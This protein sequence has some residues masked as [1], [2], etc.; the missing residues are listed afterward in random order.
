MK[1]RQIVSK[2]R[3][4]FRA[5]IRSINA[6]MLYH[7]ILYFKSQPIAVSQKS[8][9]VFSPHQ[10]DETLGCGG[11]IALKRS[12]GV[13][14]E[15]VFLTDGRYGRPDW[16]KAEMIAEIR[17]REALNALDIL[18][19]ANS[20][21]H[22]LNQIDGSLQYL[23]NDQ[24]QHIID[25]LAQRLRLFMPE[26]VYVPHRKDVHGDHE[27][28]YQ[29]VKEAIAA[30]GIQVEL[31]QYP[32]WMLWQNPL[33]FELKSE[34]IANAYRLTIDSVKDRKKQAIKTYRSQISMLPSG[35]LERF[36]LPYEI[37]FKN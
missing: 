20:Q 32:I 33:Y 9:M 23:L 35:F 1:T 15:V 19:V 14:V 18:G 31:L 2:L 7:W 29:L 5:K 13:T 28:T 11:L 21:T 25:Q 16:I 22:F 12:L 10:D 27:A 37:F 6:D 24:R 26:E 30:S 8:A 17:Q 36:F 34:D 3:G 4:I